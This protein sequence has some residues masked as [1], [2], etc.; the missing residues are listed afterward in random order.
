[1]SQYSV[2]WIAPLSIGVALMFLLDPA[3]GR[4]RRARL[5]DRTT[6]LGQRTGRRTHKMSRDLQNRA[7]GLAARFH[8]ASDADVADDAVVDARVRTAI[9][10]AS[11]HSSAIAVGVI[12]GVAELN[13]P[14]LAAEHDDVVDAVLG[15]RGVFDIVNHMTQ[16]ET[17]DGIPGLQG[18]GFMPTR[19]SRLLPS[20]AVLC[21]AAGG[22]GIIAYGMSRR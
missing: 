8:G 18:D 11:T 14:V 4:R 12:G 1:M 9:G 13:G 5:R 3:Q 22:A 20:A 16:H 10:R 19:R 17:P 2:S 21:A 6:H 7:S 15:V